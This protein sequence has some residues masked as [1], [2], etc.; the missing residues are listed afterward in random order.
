MSA[1]KN[2]PLGSNVIVSVLNHPQPATSITFGIVKKH[3]KPIFPQDGPITVKKVT[4]PQ[5]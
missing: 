2:L 5:K 3:K 1:I 4:L